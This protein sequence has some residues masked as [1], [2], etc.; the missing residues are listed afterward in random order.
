MATELLATGSTAA[1]SADVVVAAGTPVIVMMKDQTGAE[2][3]IRILLK[4][5]DGA[6]FDVGELT[7]ARPALG[8]GI[9]GTYRLTRVAGN[10]CGAFSA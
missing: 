5:E 6:Y 8:L 9:A 2:A 10:T 3:R 1:N 4:D 7:P